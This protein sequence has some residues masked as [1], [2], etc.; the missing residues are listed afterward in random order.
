MGVAL[1]SSGLH[2]TGVARCWFRHSPSHIL[3]AQELANALIGLTEYVGTV[4][5]HRSSVTSADFAGRSGIV[6]IMD[7]WGATDHI[8]V[9]NG[10]QLKAGDTSYFGRGKQVWFWPL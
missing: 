9:W 10:S 2:V 5:K 3:R 6:F 8:D 7:G 1:E 4:E